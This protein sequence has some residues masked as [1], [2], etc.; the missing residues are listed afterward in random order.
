M[1]ENLRLGFLGEKIASDYLQKQGYRIIGKN[2]HKRWGEIDLIA[3][4]GETLVFVEVKLRT[5]PLFGKP[6]EAIT[7]WKLRSLTR[8][9][10]FYKSLHPELPDLMRIDLVGIG[11]N[12]KSEAERIVLIKN[13][14]E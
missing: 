8:S 10:E 9:A 12:E 1:P 4:E 14:S 11:L 2:F 6:E 13:I 7:P 5:S 3:I